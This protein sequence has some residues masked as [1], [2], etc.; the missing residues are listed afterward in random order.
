MS[1][2]H[3]GDLLSKQLADIQAK[4]LTKRER[5]IESPQGSAVRVTGH[6]V[7][8]F[9][10]NNYLGLANHP[11]I[12]EAAHEALRRY[13]YGMASV[14]FIC[15]T[16]D[17]HKQLEAEVARFFGK[18]DAILYISCWDANGG[19]FETI[20][21]EEDA[22]LSDELNHASIIDGIRLCK[23]QRLRYKNGDMAELEKG[24]RDTKSSRLR[25]IV[26]DGVF[27]MDGSLAKLPDICALADRY[28]AIVVVDDSHATGVLGPTGR[29]TPEH[30][31][32][33]DRVDI[34]TSTLG[35]AL[36][37]AAG[38]FTCAR[39]E[40]VEILRQRSRT[41][42]FSNSL[43]P[44]IVNAARKAL[45][46]AGTGGELR[47]RLHAN[48][49]R[50]RAGLEGAG[51]HLKPG[52]HPI[53]PVMLGDAALASRMAEELLKLGIY[54]IGFSYPVVPQGQ[55]RIRLQMSAAHTPEQIDR[56]IAAFTRVGRELGLI[57]K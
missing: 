54:V 26:T 2:T 44:M 14:R 6:E 30:F 53:L 41:Y 23:A 35:K 37:G 5:R 13:G 34:I 51:F 43:P 46:L 11:D 18:D 15:G 8:N 7:L 45:E 16:Q 28:D 22:V 21:G 10:A 42:L 39:A 1:D 4:G 20:L 32:V 48:A 50:M 47:D 52:Q 27:S 38:G 25:L 31:G 29:G 40:V 17:V 36:G 49:A 33:L 19:L 9:C 24:L 12:V 56:A 57:A 55:A 3:L